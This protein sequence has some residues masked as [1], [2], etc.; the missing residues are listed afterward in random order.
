MNGSTEGRRPIMRSNKPTTAVAI[1]DSA[2]Y[3][4]LDMRRN[5]EKFP[6]ICRIPREE[7][8]PQ[9][10]MI[11]HNAFLYKGHNAD[12]T[13]IQFIAS[14]L[15]DELVADNE[16]VGTKWISLAEI[17]KVVKKAVLTDENFVSVSVASLYKVVVAYAKGEGSQLEKDIRSGRALP[18]ETHPMITAYAGKMIRR[19]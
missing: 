18:E 17:A 7:A 19:K 12:P 4:L 8:I 3:S 11:V 1:P 13:T 6:R 16:K 9:M 5:S 2:A 15:C 10:A 14:A